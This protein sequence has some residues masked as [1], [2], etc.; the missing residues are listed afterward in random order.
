MCVQSPTFFFW[1]LILRFQAIIFVFVRAHRERNFDLYVST[2]EKLAP[3]LFGLDATNYSRWLPFHVRDMKSLPST[4]LAQFKKG[5]F[6]V[7]KTKH[8]FSSIAIDQ[9]HEQSNKLIKG[10]GGLIGSFQQQDSLIQYLVNAPEIARILQDFGKFLPNWGM[11]DEDDELQHHEHTHSFQKRFHEKANNLLSKVCEYGNPFSINHPNLLNLTTQDAFDPSVQEALKNLEMKGKEQ[12]ESYVEEVLEKGTK[13]VHDTIPKNSFPLMSTPLKRISTGAG[14]RLKTIQLNSAMFSRAVA[15]LQDREISLEKLFSFELHF[16]PPAISNYGELYLPP[17]K[18]AL[19]HE[20]VTPCHNAPEEGPEV[21]DPTSTVIIDG[22]RL[23]YQFPP[24]LAMTFNQYVNHL[25]RSVISRYFIFNQRIDIIFDTYLESSLKAATRQKRGQGIRRRVAGEN[26]CPGNWPQFLK[27]TRNKDELNTFLA[28][29]LTPLSYPAGR[30]LFITCQ[31]HVLSNGTITME[32]SDHEDA[33]SRM[34]LH[35]RHALS[36]GMNRVKILSNDTD[37]VIIGLGVYHKL[38]STY[39]FEDIVIEFGM[40]KDHK[41]ISLK[42]LA[43]SLGETRCQALPFLHSFTGS[44]T[45]SAF[46]NV[47]KKKAYEA[48]KGCREAESTFA[49]LFNNPFQDLAEDSDKFKAIQQFTIRM[50]SRTS[51]L[52]DVNEARLQFYYQRSTNI[53][54]IPPTANSLFMHTRR[55]IFQCGVWSKCL[56]SQQNLPSPRNFGWKQSND[57]LLRWEPHWMTQNEAS[58]ECREFVKCVCKS[59]AC[60]ICKC[61]LASLK[62]TILCKCKCANKV[63]YE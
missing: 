9:A 37:I 48:L 4:V 15:I 13:S 49:G 62:C 30:Q 39:H 51:T 61:K 19:I 45:T 43:E 27:D 50:Y 34:M 28:E 58:K 31:E 54:F 59:E 22:G 29:S 2:L 17:D 26:K 55:S 42:A 3:F 23:T 36:Q 5:N 20:I 16:F 25:S 35:V 24:K 47:G 6:T 12:Y 53:E 14:N 7:T 56:Q 21:L 40:K 11:V 32:D 18:S 57:P 38:R 33:D 60:T 46:R 52:S 63:L 44:D 1:D 41:S 10:T 8:K